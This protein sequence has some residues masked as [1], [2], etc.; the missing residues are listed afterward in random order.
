MPQVLDLLGIHDGKLGVLMVISG[1][2][3]GDVRCLLTVQ[4]GDQN[5][6]TSAA[7]HGLQ[8]SSNLLGRLA[9]A[10]DHLAGTLAHTPVE[11][12]LRIAQVF[13]GAHLQGV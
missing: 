9:R 6:V 12:H 10:I 11:I 7:Y 3:L 13:K 4:P 8:N 5:I 1:S 2:I